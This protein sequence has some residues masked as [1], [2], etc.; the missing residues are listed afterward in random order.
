MK[1]IFIGMLLSSTVTSQHDTLEACKGR[2]VMLKEKGVIGKCVEQSI[3][4]FTFG[5]NS[6]INVLPK[7]YTCPPNSICFS[8]LNGN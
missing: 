5:S 6:N 4:F 7:Q 1:Y 8:T 2:E 3:D